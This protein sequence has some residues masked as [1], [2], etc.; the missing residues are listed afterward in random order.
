M[1][2][3]SIILSFAVYYYCVPGY[4][5]VVNTIP[6]LNDYLELH[7]TSEMVVYNDPAKVEVRQILFP[8]IIKSVNSSASS[9]CGF[10][11]MLKHSMSSSRRPNNFRVSHIFL[12][13]NMGIQNYFCSEYYCYY[14]Y[15]GLSLFHNYTSSTDLIIFTSKPEVQNQFLTNCR[16]DVQVII[17]EIEEQSSNEYVVVSKKSYKRLRQGGISLVPLI[18]STLAY[19]GSWGQNNCM[20]QYGLEFIYDSNTDP[21]FS[22]TYATG[23]KV[24]L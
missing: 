12:F 7:A 19:D 8:I 10:P 17:Y 6:R 2:R 1:V 14:P 18:C 9:L 13:Y 16:Y 21:R 15:A 3:L 22:P 24:P 23:F 4:A 5:V 20:Q 11:T